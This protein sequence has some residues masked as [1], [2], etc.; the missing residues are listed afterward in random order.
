VL[1]HVGAEFRKSGDFLKQ[2]LTHQVP[3]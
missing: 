3:V 2:L 1:D